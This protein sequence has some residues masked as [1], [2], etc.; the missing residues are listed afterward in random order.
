MT[1]RILKEI[2]DE[3]R[4]S[5]LCL[6]NSCL[7][8]GKLPSSWKLSEITMISKKGYDKTSLNGYRPISILLCISRLFERLLLRR[9]I[10]FLN[11]KKILI[12]QQSGFRNKRQTTANLFFL[13]Q[14]VQEGF[15]TK[16]DTISVFFDI[17][18]AFDKVWLDG[19]IFK[20]IKFQ[21]P[22]YLV[23]IIINYLSD[24]KFRVKADNAKSA[25]FNIET[26]VPQG[27][28]L[29]PTLFSLYINDIP[30]AASQREKE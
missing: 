2:P 27:G 30:V 9:L 11:S 20:C 15:V 24:R 8:L 26:G 12:T 22:Y 28:V 19:L 5:L 6:F 17:Q 29:S 1:N 16:N 10:R 21:V 25:Y 3:L 18:A 14:K 4:K 13:T 7:R 23:R